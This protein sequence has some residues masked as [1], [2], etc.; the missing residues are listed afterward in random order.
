MTDLITILTSDVGTG[1]WNHVKNLALGEEWDKVIIITDD[2][3]R[4]TFSDI[5]LQIIEINFSQ[6]IE[7]VIRDLSGE[8]RKLVTLHEVALNFVS[9]K[10]KEHMALVSSIM[11][12]GV[13]FRLIARTKEG[14]TE[15]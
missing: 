4:V 6:P 1:S 11:K 12:L 14:I 8:L 9:G 13:G 15:I 5:T 3:S 7:D 10:G 2:K